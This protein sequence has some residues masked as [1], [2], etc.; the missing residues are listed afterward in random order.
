MIF[1]A[2]DHNDICIVAYLF[3]D[4]S[5]EYNVSNQSKL[6]RCFLD[7]HC[8]NKLIMQPTEQKV[9]VFAKKNNK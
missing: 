1:L 9:S 3:K 6:S 7:V 4:Y 2:L 8:P 5:S